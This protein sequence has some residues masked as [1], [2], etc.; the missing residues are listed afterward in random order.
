M[1][2]NLDYIDAD[3]EIICGKYAQVCNDQL[4]NV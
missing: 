2:F 1:S 3:N 4:W